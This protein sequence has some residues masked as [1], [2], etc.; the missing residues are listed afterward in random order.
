MALFL[1]E[2][3]PVAPTS[4]KYGLLRERGIEFRQGP[5]LLNLGVSRLRLNCT[6]P[7]LGAVMLGQ[8][9]DRVADVD[10]IGA[11][12]DMV[13]RRRDDEASTIGKDR[14]GS[15]RRRAKPPPHLAS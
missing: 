14:I 5:V 7:L 13:K 10:V 12:E 6:V 3:L 2:R 11:M 9:D 4:K 15:C 8:V 1:G